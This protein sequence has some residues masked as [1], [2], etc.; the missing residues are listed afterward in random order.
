MCI[1]AVSKVITM[2]RL[3]VYIIVLAAVIWIIYRLVQRLRKP[4]TPRCSTCSDENC[5]LREQSK[6]DRADR[7]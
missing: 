1:F 3:G 6:C 5:P 7:G 2:Q 4:Q